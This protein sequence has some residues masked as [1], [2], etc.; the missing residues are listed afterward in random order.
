MGSH[1]TH[2]AM[3]AL[4]GVAVASSFHLSPIA[5]AVFATSSAGAALLPDADTPTSAVSNAGGFVLAA[6]LWAFRKSMVRHRG[7]SHT[8]LACFGFAVA[9]YE[10]GHLFTTSHGWLP[11]AWPIRIVVPVLLSMLATRSLFG[12]GEKFHPILSKG[13]RRLLIGIV[14]III[15]YLGSAIGSSPHFAFGLSL[16]VLLGYFSHLLI[17]ALMG[18]IPLFW[19]LSGS[20]EHRV[21]LAHIKTEGLVDRS[22]GWVLLFGAIVVLVLK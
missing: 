21:T 6:P 20:L 1:H 18:G 10:L 13:H 8:W 15:G 14:G 5:T 16:A 7:I 17:D 22:L 9:V 19:P 11:P 2:L 12:S 4:T 3:G